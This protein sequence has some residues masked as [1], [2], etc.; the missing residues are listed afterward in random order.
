MQDKEDK[1]IPDT[2]VDL[3][4]LPAGVLVGAFIKG[5]IDLVLK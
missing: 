1:E 5:I 3:L 2:W 4:I